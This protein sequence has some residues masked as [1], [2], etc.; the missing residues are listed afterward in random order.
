MTTKLRLADRTNDIFPV[1]G[2]MAAM[3]GFATPLNPWLVA[4][5]LA[6]SVVA[7]VHHAE[8]IAHRVGEPFERVLGFDGAGADGAGAGGGF[9]EAGA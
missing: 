9:H 3:A 8:V 4:I 5:I 1:L 7:A 6:G 2:F